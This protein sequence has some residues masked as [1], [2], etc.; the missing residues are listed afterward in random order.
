MTGRELIEKIKEHHL[1]DCEII[2]VPVR[3]NRE[4]GKCIV[5]KTGPNE[6]KVLWITDDYFQDLVFILAGE[7]TSVSDEYST[8]KFA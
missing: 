2:D 7:L 4:D 5:F 8:T 3:I 6:F 1:E